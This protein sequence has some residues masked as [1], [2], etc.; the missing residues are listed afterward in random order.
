MTAALVTFCV[1]GVL[2]VGLS[3]V[4]E[5]LRERSGRP[6]LFGVLAGP[7]A[8]PLFMLITIVSVAIGVLVGRL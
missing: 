6:L 1:G 5:R 7:F 2:M 4:Y 3:Y 8:L